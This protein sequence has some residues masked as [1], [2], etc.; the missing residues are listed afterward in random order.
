MGKRGRNLSSK[1]ARAYSPDPAFAGRIQAA[2]TG[3]T[4]PSLVADARS[5]P[6][7]S[8][9][10]HY[11][12]ANDMFAGDVLADAFSSRILVRRWI[13]MSNLRTRSLLRTLAPRLA[14]LRWP[15]WD[16]HHAA[17]AC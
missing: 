4:R 8:N 11:M 1:A 17:Q 9:D 3:E 12:F 5:A 10:P 2:L 14:L 15:I 6:A 7:S 13:Q 16:A